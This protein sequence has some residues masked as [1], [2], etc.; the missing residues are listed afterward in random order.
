VGLSSTGYYPLISGR[1]A[2][3]KNQTPLQLYSGYQYSDAAGRPYSSELTERLEML[4]INQFEFS[5]LSD[6]DRTDN[7]RDY[8]NN[9]PL[10][11]AFVMKM[12]DPVRQFA[13]YASHRSD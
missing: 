11:V 12:D 13:G 3:L 4:G 1:V 9:A 5:N 2:D 6:E 10:L 8:F 7:W